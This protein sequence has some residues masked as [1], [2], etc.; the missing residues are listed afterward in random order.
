V[1]SPTRTSAILADVKEQKIYTQTDADECDFEIR[2]PGIQEEMLNQERRKRGR[3]TLGFHMKNWD[4]KYFLLL[5]SCS[6]DSLFFD[7][8]VVSWFPNYI[9]VICGRIKSAQ[10]ACPLTN[11]PL[12][13]DH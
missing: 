5:F 4:T 13:S 6:P 12:V 3:R 11:E 10:T 1:A 2:K 8:L 9:R 7:S